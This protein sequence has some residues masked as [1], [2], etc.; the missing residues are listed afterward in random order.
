MTTETYSTS[1]A[2]LLTR[3]GATC[4]EEVWVVTGG[5]VADVQA[6]SGEHPD[7][8]RLPLRQEPIGDSTLIE[9][10]DGA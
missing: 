3:V 9:N 10:L 4:E 5:K 1:V 7:L 8:R 2:G 6:G